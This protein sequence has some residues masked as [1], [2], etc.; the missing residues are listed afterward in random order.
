MI[1]INM[2]LLTT[3]YTFEFLSQYIRVEMQNKC[4]LM[5]I[6]FKK[7]FCYTDT[8]TF[9]SIE[10]FSTISTLILSIDSLTVDSCMFYTNLKIQLNFFPY[11]KN[12]YIYPPSYTIHKTYTCILIQI[13]S[14]E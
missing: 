14:T 11:K 10:V 7:C 1:H 8:S 5:S 12:I 9:S 3:K 6:M 13:I 4:I 2:F